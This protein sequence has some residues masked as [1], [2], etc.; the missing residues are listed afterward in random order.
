MENQFKKKK[1]RRKRRRRWKQMRINLFA[2]PR[3][4]KNRSANSRR[5]KKSNFN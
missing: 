1:R 2:T 5:L 3:K 4:L